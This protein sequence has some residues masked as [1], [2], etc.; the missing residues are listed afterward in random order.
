ML[1]VVSCASA[2]RA[3]NAPPPNTGPPESVTFNPALG[4]DLAK[5][6]KLP[7]GLYYQELDAG[8]GDSAVGRKTVTIEYVA[9]LP[10]GRKV[11]S[12]RDKGQPLTFRLR[13][14][15]VIKG[16]EEGVTGMKL[17]ASRLLVIPPELGYG[18]DGK[19]TVPGNMTLVFEVRLLSVK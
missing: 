18:M 5:M 2:P 17:G 10:D 1:A 7:S 15:G 3:P 14:G 11:D 12:S 16:V 9:V 19:A 13:S 4:V 8:T 6:T